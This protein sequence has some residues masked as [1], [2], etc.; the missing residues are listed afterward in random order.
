MSFVFVHTSVFHVVFFCK[1]NISLTIYCQKL[2]MGEKGDGV[3]K[4]LRY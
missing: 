1:L 2:E 4:L 3:E